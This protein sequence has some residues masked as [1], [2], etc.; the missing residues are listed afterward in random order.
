MAARLYDIVKVL[1]SKNAGPL[2]LTFD[3]MFDDEPTYHRVRNSGVITPRWFAEAYGVPAEAVRIIPFDGAMAIKIT[4]PR[5]G[6]TSGAPDD[7][8]VYGAQQHGPLINLMIP[9]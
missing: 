1:R 7:H 4:I 6:A 8:D 3:L 2:Y 9:D 5:P